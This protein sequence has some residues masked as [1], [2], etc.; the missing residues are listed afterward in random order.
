MQSTVQVVVE[1]DGETK[2]ALAAEWLTLT[3]I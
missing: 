2:P 1:I 3:Y